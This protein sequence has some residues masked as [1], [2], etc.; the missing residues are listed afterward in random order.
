MDEDHD[1]GLDGGLDGEEESSTSTESPFVGSDIEAEALAL[2]TDEWIGRTRNYPAALSGGGL[3]RENLAR[4]LNEARS[5]AGPSGAHHLSIQGSAGL[6]GGLTV[7]YDQGQPSRAESERAPI[8]PY[9]QGQSNSAGSEDG[10]IVPSNQGQPS[11][12]ISESGIDRQGE[13]MTISLRGHRSHS[14]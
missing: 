6:E 11:R 1:S 7:P 10:H 8:I 2:G 3:T 12:P 9:N 4:I 14:I 13:Q 5:G